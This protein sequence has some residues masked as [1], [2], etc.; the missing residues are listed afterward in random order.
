M[1]I[2]VKHGFTSPVSDTTDPDLI[3]PSHWNADH[4]LDLASGKVIG[5]VSAGTGAAEE[6]TLDTDTA[7][8]A[9][10][11][12]VIATQKATKAYVDTAFAGAVHPADLALVAVSGAYS[13]LTGKPTIP[14]ALSAL[15]GSTDNVSEGTTNLYF[16][17][18]RVLATALTGLS[19]A[20]NAAITATD[21][22]LSAL[23]KLQK[24][25]TDLGTSKANLAS[26]TFTGTVSGITKSMVGLGSV[27]N[28]SDATKNSATA[29]LTNKRITA[30]IGTEASSA[31]STPTAD[32]VDQWNVTALA[33]ADAFAAP[34]GTPTDGQKLVIRIKD[35]GTA[36]ALTWN[37]IYRALGTTLPTTTVVSKTLYLGF[38]YNAADTKWDCVAVAQEA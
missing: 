22:V 25:I 21:T 1:T 13:D 38:I 26:P 23:G 5:R 31:T 30:R 8:T 37:A 6:L 33:A 14:T 15:T 12:S 9:D 24:Q 34:S 18:A 4:A 16:T 36:R 29:T 7:L 27:D 17:V 2:S 28:T 10:S 19:T 20:T 11:D 3:Q 35:N 32:S